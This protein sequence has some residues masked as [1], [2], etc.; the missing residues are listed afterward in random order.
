MGKSV[1]PPPVP[2]FPKRIRQDSLSSLKTH[3][4]LMQ[5]KSSVLTCMTVNVNH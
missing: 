2:G 3:L 1:T 4:N 5:H